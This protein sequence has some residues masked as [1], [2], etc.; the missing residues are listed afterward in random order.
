MY[1]YNWNS[2]LKI[3]V[4]SVDYFSETIA[5]IKLIKAFNLKQNLLDF[6]ITNEKNIKNKPWA[7]NHLGHFISFGILPLTVYVEL[8]LLNYIAGIFIID[9]NISNVNSYAGSS[10]LF[11]IYLIVTT[12]IWK[13]LSDIY[14]IFQSFGKL[15]E[16]INKKYKNLHNEVINVFSDNNTDKKKFDNKNCVNAVEFQKASCENDSLNRRRIING[17]IEFRNVSFSYS[18]EKNKNKI[19]DNLSFIIYPGSKVGFVGSSGCGKSTIIQLLLRFYEPNEGEI[20]LDEINIKDFEVNELRDYFSGVFQ[21]P[22]LF[23][24]SIYENIKYGNLNATDEQIVAVALITQIPLMLLDKSNNQNIMQISG[25]QK[26]K[27]A[28]ARCLL[29]ERKVYFFDEATSALDINTEMKIN[30]NLDNYFTNL[31]EEKTLI[32]IAHRYFCYSLFKLFFY[33]K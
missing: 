6:L 9:N 5:N 15:N 24:R 31:E 8:G 7:Y 30:Y 21:E 29:K 3:D 14:Y 28:L 32:I 27:I 12:L 17:K 1:Y 26:Q 2:K 19:I 23:E 10:C 25:G 33:R 11:F 13:Y 16:F 22:D 18:S 20:F 4:I